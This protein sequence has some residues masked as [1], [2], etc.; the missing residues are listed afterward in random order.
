[1]H[2]QHCFGY[3]RRVDRA[4]V[5]AIGVSL[6]VE[7]GQPASAPVYRVAVRI[8][9]VDVGYEVNVGWRGPLARLDQYALGFVGVKRLEGYV[10]A[11]RQVVHPGLVTFKK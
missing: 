9:D 1:M 2:V 7:D 5:N 4:V 3:E 8:A 6:V 11:V 10:V